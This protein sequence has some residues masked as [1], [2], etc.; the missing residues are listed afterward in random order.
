MD[1]N[2]FDK[3]IIEQYKQEVKAKWGESLPLLVSKDQ[4]HHS[5]VEYVY[6]HL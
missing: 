4:L 1:F 2:V 3:S 6:L 5:D